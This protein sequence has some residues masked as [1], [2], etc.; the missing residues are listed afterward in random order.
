MI[1]TMVLE[2]FLRSGRTALS[3]TFRECSSPLSRL[4]CID[5]SPGQCAISTSLRRFSVR[6]QAIAVARFIMKDHSRTDTVLDFLLVRL[7]VDINT[8]SSC[9]Q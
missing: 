5:R 4:G 2:S 9:S 7:N 1:L 6:H 8:K 3:N